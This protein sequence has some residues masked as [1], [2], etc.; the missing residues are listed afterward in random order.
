MVVSY[1]INPLAGFTIAI[2]DVDEV[3]GISIPFVLLFTSNIALAC[4]VL[5]L[6][7]TDWAIRNVENKMPE[8]DVKNNFFTVL[9]LI[10]LEVFI[11]FS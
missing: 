6:M 3:L 9:F 2:R 4:G 10:S 7:P 5:L 1:N 8:T 11:L